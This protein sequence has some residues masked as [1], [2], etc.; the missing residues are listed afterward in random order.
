M[1]RRNWTREELILAINLYCKI[2]FGKINKNNPDVI[3][4]AKLIGRTP[5]S[6]SFKLGNFGSFD[7]SLKER[8]VGGLPNTGKLDKE[9]WDEFYQNWEERTFESERLRAQF[10][11]KSLD[12]LVDISDIDIKEGKEK[13]RIVKT[14]VNQSFFRSMVLASYNFTCCITGIKNTELLVASHI[15]PWAE[16]SENRL[17]PRN[18]LCLNALHD[19][20][21]DQY[22]ITV[23]PNFKLKISK[24]LITEKKNKSIQE[25][26]LQFESLEIKLPRKFI[27]DEKLLLQHN[28]IF[29]ERN[30]NN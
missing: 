7:P 13:E 30:G 8:G 22:L 23:T 29:S 2:P 20:A 17:N 25:N 15:V 10:E 4:L 1:E 6:I 11:N 14:R 5:S 19:K 26:F 9:I 12:Q 18:G 21:F 24:K 28:K 3:H 27:P 16:D